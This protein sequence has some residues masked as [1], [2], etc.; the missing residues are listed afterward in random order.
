MVVPAPGTNRFSDR[1]FLAIV[2]DKPETRV[3]KRTSKGES[4]SELRKD[5]LPRGA[6]YTEGLS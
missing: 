4:T 3:I 2:E 1:W 6:F 5:S